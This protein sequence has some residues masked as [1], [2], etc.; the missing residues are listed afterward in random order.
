MSSTVSNLSDITGISI[1]SDDGEG[2]MEWRNASTWVEKQIQKGTNPRDVLKVLFSD[3][4]EI[5]ER[6]DDVIL[7]QVCTDHSLV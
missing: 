2:A 7:W 5:P 3:P 1:L 4:A 6:V